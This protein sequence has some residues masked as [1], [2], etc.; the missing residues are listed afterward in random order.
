M[1][2]RYNPNPKNAKVG[3]CPVRAIAKAEDIGWEQAYSELALQGFIMADMPNANAV[4]GE[5]LKGKG[6][7]RK[8]LEDFTTVKQFCADHQYG[9]YVL[10]LQ[11]HVVCAENGNHYDSFDSGNE[12]VLYFWT[13][14]D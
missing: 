1:F 10:A 9:T 14:E 2:V 7:K 8:F 6:Y 12:T 5:W 11:G 13:K 4:W 3:D